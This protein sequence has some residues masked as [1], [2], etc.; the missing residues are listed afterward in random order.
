MLMLTF[1]SS[2][3]LSVF[4]GLSQG[5]REVAVG[6]VADMIAA[7]VLPGSFHIRRRLFWNLGVFCG[8]G[9][10]LRRRPATADEQTFT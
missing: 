10:S 8:H 4:L 3:G 9:L 2:G 1:H 5:G 6:T 7:A